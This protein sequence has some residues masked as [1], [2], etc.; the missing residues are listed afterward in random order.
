M[1]LGPLA[2]IAVGML[3]LLANLGVLPAAVVH[4]MFAT[5]WPLLPI[6]AGVAAL[7]VRHRP[8]RMRQAP[9]ADD[10]A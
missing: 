8:C 6:G 5:W 9:E 7:S 1:R 4:E 10:S 3:F 2:L